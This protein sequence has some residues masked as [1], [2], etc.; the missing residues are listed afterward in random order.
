MN[1]LPQSIQRALSSYKPSLKSDLRYRLDLLIR[2]VYD[3]LRD[4]DSPEVNRFRDEIVKPLADLCVVV[5]RLK[6]TEYDRRYGYVSPV[7]QAYAEGNHLRAIEKYCPHAVNDYEYRGEYYYDRHEQE[8]RIAELARTMPQ[9]LSEITAA[10]RFEDLPYPVREFLLDYGF[11]PHA[12]FI[13]ES[14][15]TDRTDQFQAD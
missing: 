9:L 3:H 6:E 12:L 15:T 5:E 2:G 1:E 7:L 11:H 13:E 8:T 14:S 4:A 10:K